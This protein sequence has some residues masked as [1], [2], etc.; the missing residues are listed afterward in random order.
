MDPPG[1]ALESF[2]VMGAW[3]DRYRAVNGEVPSEKGIGLDG[4][5]FKFHYALPVDPSGEL[6][7]GR[8]FDDIRQLKAMLLEDEAHIARNLIRQLTI[9][10]T[11]APIGF[12]DRSE[13]EAMLARTS[14]GHYG[15]RSIVHEIVQ[16]TLFQHR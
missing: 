12:S 1:L 3:R 15:V 8:Q 10:A 4:Q 5:S 13:I 2:D 16:S 14:S 7:D 6:L 11:G 9:Y